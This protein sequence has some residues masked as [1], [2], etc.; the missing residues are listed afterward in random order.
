MLIFILRLRLNIFKE[1]DRPAT[2][3]DLLRPMFWGSRYV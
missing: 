1:P 2:R 3:G